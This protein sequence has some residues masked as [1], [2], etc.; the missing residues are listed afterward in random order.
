VEL[1]GD[2]KAHSVAAFALDAF[3]NTYVKLQGSPVSCSDGIQNQGELDVDCGGP[4]AACRPTPVKRPV[5]PRHALKC[6]DAYVGRDGL[7]LL[8]NYAHKGGTNDPLAPTTL[9][10][11]P[12]EGFSH[13]T[14]TAAF[15]EGVIHDV[16]EAR[17][18]C[19]TSAHGR[20]V[21]FMTTDRTLLDGV[22]RNSFVAGPT[23]AWATSTARLQVVDVAR[24]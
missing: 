9:P 12:L 16:T 19:T 11:D 10:T 7:T 8:L 22:A 15:G 13:A 14:A 23:S 20:V 6:K 21:S 18:Y 4:C 24:A 2:G 3:T 5:C 1:L 17:F